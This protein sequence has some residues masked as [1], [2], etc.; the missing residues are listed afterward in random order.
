MKA[1]AK[2][3]YPSRKLVST[4]HH[5]ANDTSL[6]NLP[7]FDSFIAIQNKISMHCKSLINA[8]PMY[9]WLLQDASLVDSGYD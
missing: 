2:K 9:K 7:H 5:F 4:L 3:Y 8:I 1:K 6:M